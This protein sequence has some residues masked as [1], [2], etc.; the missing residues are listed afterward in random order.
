MKN[1]IIASLMV[2]IAAVSALAQKD[3]PFPCSCGPCHYT[4]C[5]CGLPCSNGLA[6]KPTPKQIMQRVLNSTGTL[7]LGHP[8][9]SRAAMYRQKCIIG[10]S[11][12]LPKLASR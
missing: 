8:P 1:L 11:A 5:D 4:N 9:I 12:H 3:D 2:L 10:Q 7:P 6:V